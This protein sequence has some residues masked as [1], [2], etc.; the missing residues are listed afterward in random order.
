MLSLRIAFQKLA[1]AP[2]T[3]SRTWCRGLRLVPLLGLDDQID[4]AFWRPRVLLP[5]GSKA[6]PD[7]VQV[8]DRWH[9]M[10]NAS[11]AFLDSA[12]KSTR[13]IRKTLGAT[14]VNPKLLTS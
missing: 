11:S 13:Q 5:G 3:A 7:A 9:L 10:E 2:L 6:L 12:R 1:S 4:V 14:R 8:A